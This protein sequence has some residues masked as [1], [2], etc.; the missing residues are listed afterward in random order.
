MTVTP[1]TLTTDQVAQFA[2]LPLSTLHTWVR[3]HRVQ[4]S[5]ARS[6]GRR[7]PLLWSAR[8]AVGVRALARLRRAGVSGQQLRRVAAY[9]RDTFDTELQQAT[10]VCSS[11]DLWYV[12]QAGTHTAVLR[13]LGQLSLVG[14]GQTFA[15]VADTVSDTGVLVV[16]PVGQWHQQATQL[17]QAV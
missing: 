2:D 9:V 5:V 8:D 14:E 3:T 15:E 1:L 11:S 12:D 4:P 16:L 10:L 6:R 17:A 13:N 7:R